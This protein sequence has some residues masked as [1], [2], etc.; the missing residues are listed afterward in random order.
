MVRLEVQGIEVEPLRLHLGAF[1]NFP[2][3]AHEDVR[4]AVLQGGQGVAGTGTATT[5][6]GSDIHGFLDED[7][8]VVLCFQHLGTGCERLVDPSAGGTHELA[9][10]SLVLLGQAADFAVG[11]AQRRLLAGVGEADSLEFF[12][13]GS[14]CDGSE[15]VLDGG[16]DGGFIQRIRAGS[17]WQSVSHLLFLATSRERPA[18][19]AWKTKRAV[20]AADG[21][22][23]PSV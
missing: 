20:L 7:A 11:E 9:R 18:M 16:G 22:H 19:P 14:C 21:R 2:A 1:G 17:A 4:D 5:R 15:R 8:G 10:S 3:H 6:R 23:Y 12:E 13:G